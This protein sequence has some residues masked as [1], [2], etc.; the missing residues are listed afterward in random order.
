M[1]QLA[2]KVLDESI[3]LE[4][5]NLQAEINKGLF[6]KEKVKKAQSLWVSKGGVRGRA[7]FEII[8][9]EL[10]SLCVF[11][12]VCNYCEQ[13]EA[14]DI[15]HIFPKSFFPEKT[16]AWENYLLA[17]KQCNSAFK[18]DKCH[19][20]NNFDELQYVVRGKEPPFKRVAFINPRIEDPSIFM[21][22]NLLTFKFEEIPGISKADSNRVRSTLEI[23]ELN[24]RDVLL[25]A[26]KSTARY[27]HELLLRLIKILNSSDVIELGNNLS[28]Y[29]DRFDLTKPV[30]DIKNEIK[31]SYKSHI[32]RY[33]HPSVWQSIKLIESKFNTK[34]IAIFKEIPEALNW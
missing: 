32:M 15:E 6:F 34:W 28:P 20:L 33:Q 18:L 29:D 16:F 10:Y 1:I 14:N 17:C 30:S 21:I 2:T 12:G 4:L 13:S 24:R 26:R 8:R 19:V 25:E 23:L 31:T 5:S 27:Y 3:N 22:L 9:K 11:E 7:A